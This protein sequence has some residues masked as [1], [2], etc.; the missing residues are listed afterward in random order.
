[1]IR[2]YTLP[3]Y[4]IPYPHILINANEPDEGVRYIKRH[5]NA[6]RA[7]IIDS[8]VEIFRD[9]HVKEYP[10]GPRAWAKRL[11]RLYSKVGALVPDAE[12]YVTALDYPDDYHPGNLWLS[13]MITNV[14]RTIEN[15][16]MCIKEYPDVRWLIPVQGHYRD[17]ASLA[18][19]LTTYDLLGVLERYNYVALANLCVE[20]DVNLIR[21]SVM[22]ASKT[23]SMLGV[24]ARIHVFGLKI[25]SLRDVNRMIYSFDSTAWTRPVNKHAR[26]VRD[27]SAKT[28]KEREQFFC[29]YVRHL[30]KYVQPPRETLEACDEGFKTLDDTY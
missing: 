28:E 17:P 18:V 2:F 19:S 30:S 4:R 27:A 20:P 16:K 13:D 6:I 21:L 22:V 11:V 10:G 7:V 29:H 8:G 25:A 23:L 12:V 3:P 1:M 5:R 9:P 26:R 24:K 15:V 14:E